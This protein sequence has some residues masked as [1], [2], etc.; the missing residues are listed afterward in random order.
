MYV[1]FVGSESIYELKNELKYSSV[2]P[3]RTS[4]VLGQTCL[5]SRNILRNWRISWR[6]KRIDW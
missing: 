4:Y 6:K 5:D 3:L 1:S 2:V